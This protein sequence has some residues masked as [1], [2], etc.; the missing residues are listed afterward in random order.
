MLRRLLLPVGA[1]L[2]L[3]SAFS[4]LHAQDPKPAVAKPADA[5]PVEPKPPLA[6]TVRS[7]MTRLKLGESAVVTVAVKNVTKAPEVTMP[8]QA[9]ATIQLLSG[10]EL[11]PSILDGVEPQD[12]P[13][14]RNT[15][16]VPGQ[17]IIEA[18]RTLTGATPPELLDGPK[19]KD[20]D[21]PKGLREARAGLADLQRNDWVFRYLVTP[22]APGLFLLQTFTVKGP[23]G[24]IVK[25]DPIAIKVCPGDDCTSCGAPTP[26]RKTSIK[27]IPPNPKENRPH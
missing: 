8:Q 26:P 13:V 19:N 23:D 3:F 12:W 2:A 17:R 14:Y 16:K 5:K 4:S 1:L 18:M 25:T 7:D 24:Q 6:V 20:V 10:P 27:E 11:R 15:G 22:S 9:D 21:P